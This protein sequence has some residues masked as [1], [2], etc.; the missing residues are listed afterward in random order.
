MWLNSGSVVVSFV[1]VV[2]QILS[3]FSPWHRD[4]GISVDCSFL[5]Q[6]ASAVVGLRFRQSVGWTKSWRVA[7]GFGRVGA[8]GRGVHGGLHA[9]PERFGWDDATSWLIL[10]FF[11]SSFLPTFRCL[12]FPSYFWQHLLEQ[13]QQPS[14]PPA[15]SN[16]QP[17]QPKKQV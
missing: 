8:G 12:E 3:D 17:T 14:N 13:I 2:A 7:L 6:V 16:N 10:V 11:E 1:V 15:L 9:G 5:G 4:P